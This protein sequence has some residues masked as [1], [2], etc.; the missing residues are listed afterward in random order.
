[1]AIAS[2]IF[3]YFPVILFFPCY[4]PVVTSQLYDCGASGPST[5][6]DFFQTLFVGGINI[7]VVWQSL[8]DCLVHAAYIA[9]LGCVILTEYI[10]V[11]NRL[12]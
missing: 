12:I 7:I 9:F 4:P 6:I 8:L 5:I 11:I 1:M 10:L 3:I 2:A